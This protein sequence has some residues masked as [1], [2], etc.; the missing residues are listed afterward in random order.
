MEFFVVKFL[1]GVAKYSNSISLEYKFFLYNIGTG[2]TPNHIGSG[3]LGGN[4][5]VAGPSIGK[6]IGNA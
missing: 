1:N 6:A 5:C 2:S 3:I 4:A